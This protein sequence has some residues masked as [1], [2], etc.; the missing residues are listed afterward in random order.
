MRLQ[1]ERNHRTNR[2]LNGTGIT[3]EIAVVPSPDAWDWRLSLAEVS[4]DGPFSKLPGVDRALIVAS[5]AGMILR[6]DRHDHAIRHHDI[7]RFDGAS[8]TQCSLLDG[9]VRDLNLMVRRD[10]NIG[11]PSL[12]LISLVAGSPVD[13]GDALGFVVLDGVVTLTTIGD[14]FP[15]SPLV[16]HAT[17]FDAV[18]ADGPTRQRTTCVVRRDA[19]VVVASL[20]CEV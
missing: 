6:I 18:L 16:E 5:G 15:F 7:F 4:T 2:W 17:R 8:D 3:L 9:P 14:S 20:R 12:E 10:A 13:L 1:R 11:A 19:V